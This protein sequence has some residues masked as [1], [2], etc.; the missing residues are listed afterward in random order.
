LELDQGRVV[1]RFLILGVQMGPDIFNEECIA[2]AKVL[3]TNAEKVGLLAFAVASTRLPS[4]ELNRPGMIAPLPSPFGIHPPPVFWASVNSAN[5]AE[6]I[7]LEHF[8]GRKPD[9]ERT[10][11]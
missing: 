3:G 1:I 10:R 9:F 8:D 11:E 5:Q 4:S 2:E 7:T 6:G